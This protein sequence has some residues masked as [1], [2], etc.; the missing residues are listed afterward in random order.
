MPF[1]PPS[2]LVF[3]FFTLALA[4]CQNANHLRHPKQLFEFGLQNVS[5]CLNS[6]R[7]VHVSWFSCSN[8]FFVLFGC[9]YKGVKFYSNNQEQFVKSGSDTEGLVC[10][11]CDSEKCTSDWLW[12]SRKAVRDKNCG[13]L[14]F[15]FFTCVSH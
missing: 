5:E 14:I 9:M 11:G 7:H 10:I 6:Q 4:K 12:P 3:I 2:V 1:L 13:F 15:F 8:I